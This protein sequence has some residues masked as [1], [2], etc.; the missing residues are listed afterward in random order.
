VGMPDVGVCSLGMHSMGM[1]CMGLHGEDVP[2]VRVHRALHCLSGKKLSIDAFRKTY[3]NCLRNMSLNHLI[4][5]ERW[6]LI[7]KL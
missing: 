5:T 3:A 6:P 2:G 4:E 7:D 1:Y